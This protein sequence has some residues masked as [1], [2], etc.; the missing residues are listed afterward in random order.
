MIPDKDIIRARQALNMA[1]VRITPGEKRGAIL[2]V[3]A[4]ARNVEDCRELLDA[5]GLDPRDRILP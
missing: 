5:L 2:A 1:D 4:A 3:A